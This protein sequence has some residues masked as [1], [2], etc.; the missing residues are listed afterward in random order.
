[1]EVKDFELF[2]KAPLLDE[3]VAIERLRQIIFDDP[4]FP[5]EYSE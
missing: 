4:S 1:L 5:F 3:A 2:E